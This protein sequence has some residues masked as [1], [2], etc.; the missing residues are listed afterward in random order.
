M[1]PTPEKEA[2]I[3]F[4]NGVLSSE[5]VEAIFNTLPVEITFV[6]KD[7]IVQYFNQPKERI[8]DR[9]K[10]AIGRTVQQ[11]HSEKTIP[12]V[13]QILEDLKTGKKDVVEFWTNS[14]DRLIHIRYFSV[15]NKNG[16]NLGCL[17]VAQDITNIKKN[18]GEK[19]LLSGKRHLTE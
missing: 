1:T 12:A 17:E 11:C 10:T 5:E 16:E 19:R 3:S 18:E 4:E 15:R 7:D 2:V 6:D 9:P 13:N 14:K 8:F